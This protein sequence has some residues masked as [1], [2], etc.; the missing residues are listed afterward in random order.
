TKQPGAAL[1]KTSHFGCRTKTH[2]DPGDKHM[3]QVK[4][5]GYTMFLDWKTNLMH[6][7]WERESNRTV[8]VAQEFTE[9]RVNGNLKDGP[10]SDNF[11]F[12][13]NDIAKRPWKTVGMQIAAGKL[14]TE[15]GQYLSR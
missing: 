15:I 2:A 10:I 4:I 6:R 13:P 7:I 9:Y 1:A 11:V 5:D 8:Q 3:V 14:V 12:T